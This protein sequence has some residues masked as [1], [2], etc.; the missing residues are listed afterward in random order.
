VLIR[1][2]IAFADSPFAD[3]LVWAESIGCSS[4]R[5]QYQSKQAS[6]AV[7][8]SGPG[9]HYELIADKNNITSQWGFTQ[10]S[11][12]CLWPEEAAY[13]SSRGSLRMCSNTDTGSSSCGTTAFSE[14][15][16]TTMQAIAAAWSIVSWTWFSGYCEI[17]RT[18]FTTRRCTDAVPACSRGTAASDA[19][20]C[21]DI[22][23]SKGFTKKK[24][25]APVAQ[26]VTFDFDQQAFSPHN[27]VLALQHSEG[28]SHDSIQTVKLHAAVIASD[29]T[30]LCYH[31]AA[32]EAPQHWLEQQHQ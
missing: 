31:V 25:T 22:Y 2:H 18:V 24:A 19:A 7:L 1:S 9:C 32:F 21:T 16:I 29:G 26:L 14:G 10:D 8:A 17:D 5:P 11:K 13:L 28:A 4:E 27:C 20:P 3:V 30:A 15:H 6:T 12:L 23:L